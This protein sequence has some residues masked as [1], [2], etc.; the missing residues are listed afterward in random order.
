MSNHVVHGHA[1]RISATLSVVVLSTG[2]RSDLE[3]AIQVITP[4]VRRYG[5]QLIVA[6]AD[7]GLP[8]APVLREHPKAAFVRVPKGASRSQLCDAGMA[9]ATGDIVALRDDSAVSGAD[10]L[11]SF[12]DTVQVSESGSEILIA[13]HD[14]VASGNG[15][16]ADQIGSTLDG[17]RPSER[18]ESPESGSR[19][20]ATGDRRSDAKRAVAH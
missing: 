2:S 6:R 15:R 13:N 3:R 1:S 4:S 20:A 16:P 11:D 19:R 7:D 17:R 5:A 8:S 18:L 14:N 12:S 10:W 9:A